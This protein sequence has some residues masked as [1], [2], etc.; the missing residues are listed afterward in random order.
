MASDKD[1]VNIS[2]RFSK[3][4]AKTFLVFAIGTLLILFLAES[5]ALK[6]G[7]VL[8]SILFLL[9]KLGSGKKEPVEDAKNETAPANEKEG[10]AQEGLTQ[11]APRAEVKTSNKEIRKPKMPEKQPVKEEKPAAA[12]KV[13]SEETEMTND[14]WAEFFATLEDK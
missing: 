3:S 7:C 5:S 12:P 11:E 6:I 13:E 8:L 10:K 4:D 2:I 14:E 1:E 9:G